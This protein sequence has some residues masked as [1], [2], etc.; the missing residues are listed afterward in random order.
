MTE[1]P[2]KPFE[3]STLLDAAT[4]KL[5]VAEERWTQISWNN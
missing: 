5:Q 4:S 1:A 2:D 3:P